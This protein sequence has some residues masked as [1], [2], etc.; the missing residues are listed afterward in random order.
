MPTGIA[1]AMLTELQGLARVHPVFELTLSG[2]THRFADLPIASESQG[3]YEPFVQQWGIIERG[4][5]GPGD[6]SLQNSRTTVSVYD[7]KRVLQKAMGG[8]SSGALLDS[9]AKIVLRSF[10]VAQASH[11]ELV[12]GIIADYRLT[13]DRT[14]Q[15]VIAPDDRPLVISSNEIPTILQHDWTNLPKTSIGVDGQAV[16]GHHLST[17]VEGATGLVNCTM[18]DEDNHYWYISV[19]TLEEVINVWRNGTLDTS[20][21]TVSSWTTKSGALYTV[22]QDDLGT[23]T[24]SDT[25]TVDVKGI[26]DSTTLA[27][28]TD[29]VE[30]LEDFLTNYTTVSINSTHFTETKAFLAD[31]GHVCAKVI[32]SSD[33]P[34]SVLN[35]WCKSF[36]ISPF[37]AWDWTLGIR[38]YNPA[39]STIYLDSRHI[40]QVKQKILS[41]IEGSTDRNKV[42]SRITTNYLF[43][44]STS[45]Y[46]FQR[47]VQDPDRTLVSESESFAYGKARVS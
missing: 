28:I 2:T 24:D 4:I 19:G 41:N 1:A 35:N 7:A 5:S 42:V 17:G 8:P 40:N 11:Y 47:R 12:D 38:P 22:I 32:K 30:V 37:W 44:D 46:A 9:V 10:H 31:R 34:L 14:W 45:A 33:S 43:Q 13:G 23:S 3:R 27:M 29:P 6:Y 25:I 26:E 16:Y 36:K 39:P 15:F 21:F 18:I 20:N